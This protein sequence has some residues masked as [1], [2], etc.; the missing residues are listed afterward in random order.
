LPFFAFPES[1]FSLEILLLLFFLLFVKKLCYPQP[2]AVPFIPPHPG[3]WSPVAPPEAGKPLPPN[4]L[5]LDGGE[6]ARQRV[7]VGVLPPMNGE[8]VKI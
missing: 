4:P 5:P 7:K 8:D 1:F 2:V 6:C 3:P